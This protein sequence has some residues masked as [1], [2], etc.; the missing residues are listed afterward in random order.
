MIDQEIANLKGTRVVAFYMSLGLEFIARLVACYEI[1]II[2]NVLGQSMTFIEAYM[3]VAFSSLF[4][5]LLFFFPLQIGTR[6]GGI[7]LALQ[8]IKLNP[9]V[10][11]S[12]SLIMRIREAFWI[13]LGVLFMKFD[14]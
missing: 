8:A 3:V 2:V 10:A 9:A 12:V 13:A 1:Y 14:K 6:E 7:Y 5:N 4:A 11:V